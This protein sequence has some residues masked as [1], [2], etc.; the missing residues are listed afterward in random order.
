M[1]IY[2]IVF[3]GGSLLPG[4]TVCIGMG[5]THPFQGILLDILDPFN[6]GYFRK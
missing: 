2:L 5:D 4:H 3:A 1:Q 6:G